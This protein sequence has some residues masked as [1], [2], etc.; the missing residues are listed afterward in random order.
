MRALKQWHAQ[1][2]FS[3]LD[4]VGQSGRGQSQLIRRIDNTPGAHD[5]A[6]HLKMS[7][8][9]AGTFHRCFLHA[10]NP[11]KHTKMM[12]AVQVNA[13]CLRKCFSC[14]RLDHFSNCDMRGVT[15]AVHMG[16]D[17]AVGGIDQSIGRHHLQQT[18]FHSWRMD[19]ARIAQA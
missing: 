1:P 7:N 19:K 8:V 6:D 15:D 14:D 13:A 4:P 10:E 2:S 17:D 11:R 18:S 9:E 5:G 3:F 16:I 12:R